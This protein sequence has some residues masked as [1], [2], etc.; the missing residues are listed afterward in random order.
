MKISSIS[1][2]YRKLK[3]SQ[4]QMNVVWLVEAELCVTC[5]QLCILDQMEGLKIGKYRE[6]LSWGTGACTTAGLQ[7]QIRQTSVRKG[8][9]V[10]DPALSTGRKERTS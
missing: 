9:D 7:N 3:G 2:P 5:H 4:Q 10:F 6:R 1:L 8:G